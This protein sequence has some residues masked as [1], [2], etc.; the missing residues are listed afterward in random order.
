MAW[1]KGGGRKP[2]QGKMA[3]ALGRGAYA[4]GKGAGTVVG[5]TARR[6]WRAAPGATA[7]WA[8]SRPYHL[9]PWI[10]LVAAV[11]L[12]PRTRAEPAVGPGSKIVPGASDPRRMPS[13]QF[14]AEQPGRGRDAVRPTH[15][16]LLGWRDVIWRVILEIT[17]DKLPSVAGGVTFYALLA[18]FPA[19]GAFVSLYGLF[20]DVATVREQLNEMSAVFPASVIQ[21]VGDQMLRIAGAHDG[22]LTVAFVISLLISVW[23]ANA[24]MKALF[25]GLNVAYDEAESRPFFQQ[26]ALSYVCTLGALVFLASVAG[27]LVALPVALNWFGLAE[28]RLISSPLRWSLV[29]ALAALA[30]TLLYRIGPSRANAKWR[31]LTWGAVAASALWLGGSL[32]FSWYVGNLANFDATYGPLGAVIAFMMWVWF[33]VMTVLIGAELNAEIEHQTAKDSTTGPPQPMGQ[34]GAAMADTVGEAL[35][36]SETIEG[37]VATVRGV[38]NRLAK[39][40]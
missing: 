27:I 3:G 16:P 11:G 8:K 34:R 36:L 23:S 37:G 1:F 10:A 14:A 24:G 29:L 19:I 13:A 30:F 25:E 31:W 9:L 35:D 2:P 22:K 28:V 18:I 32:V 40:K 38:W 17:Q 26:T 20:A 7:N 12:W 4:V 6:D 33:S 5:W 39:R 15:I 21:I